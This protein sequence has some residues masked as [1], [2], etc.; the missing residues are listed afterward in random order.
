MKIPKLIYENWKE[1]AVLVAIGLISFLLMMDVDLTGDERAYKKS[2]IALIGFI[3]GELNSLEFGTKFISHGYFMP[4]MSV[5]L[6]PVVS[7]ELEGVAFVYVARVW[8]A[9]IN[10]LIVFL[11]MRE[12]K[13][14]FRSRYLSWGFLLMFLS[15]YALLYISTLWADMLGCLLAIYLA[16]KFS[17]ISN[18]TFSQASIVGLGLAM[19]VY[20][21]GNYILLLPV[22]V[23]FEIFK[24]EPD[25]EGILSRLFYLAVSIAICIILILPWSAH[26]SKVTDINTLTTTSLKMNQIIGFGHPSYRDR[27]VSE[28]GGKH[29]FTAVNR[30]VRQRA[31]EQGNSVSDQYKIEREKSLE[32]VSTDQLFLRVSKNIERYLLKPSNF[33]KRFIKKSCERDGLLCKISEYTN[34]YYQKLDT[35]ISYS[36]MLLLALFMVLPFKALKCPELAVFAKGMIFLYLAH[37]LLSFAHSRYFVQFFPVFSLIICFLL[38]NKEQSIKLIGFERFF[39]GYRRKFWPTSRVN[40]R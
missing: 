32:G 37:P 31:D 12:L 13:N 4:G 8:I 17:T 33:P 18:W 14:R 1:L 16:L 3:N 5:I 36:V 20:L 35:T 38:A 39:Y 6:A 19:M 22:F 34:G 11:I 26:V 10:L 2:A 21:R 15:P 29:I 7:F 28:G 24:A 27:L 40:N 25:R 30:A 9:S 23:A